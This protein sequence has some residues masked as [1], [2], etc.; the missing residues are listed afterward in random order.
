MGVT[1]TGSGHYRDLDSWT[2][3]RDGGCTC[4]LSLPLVRDT[5]DNTFRYKGC[6]TQTVECKIKGN[7]FSFVVCFLC[8]LFYF[9]NFQIS[10]SQRP[11]WVAG[12]TGGVGRSGLLSIRTCRTEK[13]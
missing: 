3:G 12:A 2:K 13:W 8:F 5:N 1:C 9:I 11:R 7:I 10:V 4:P 6:P